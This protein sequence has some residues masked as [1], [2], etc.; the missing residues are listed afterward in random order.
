MTKMEQLVQ[1]AARMAAAKASAIPGWRAD[2]RGLEQR[3]AGIE[4]KI[5]EASKV[6]K[7][8]ATYQ[9]AMQ[10][11]KDEDPPCP[12]CWMDRGQELA[13]LPITSD[14]PE[15][16]QYGCMECGFEA[17]FPAQSVRSRTLVISP[18]SVSRAA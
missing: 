12:E 1:R 16:V 2:I 7:R 10:A 9:E 14:T 13:L 17:S 3:K 6:E 8:L 5:D 18:S 11:S 4:R 15:E